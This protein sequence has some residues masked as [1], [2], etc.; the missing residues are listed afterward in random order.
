[1]LGSVL[2]FWQIK[3]GSVGQQITIWPACQLVPSNYNFGSV[4]LAAAVGIVSDLG[5]KCSTRNCDDSQMHLLRSH[6]CVWVFVTI[7]SLAEYY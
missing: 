1:M 6:Q 3:G 5:P 7:V 4:W 2:P